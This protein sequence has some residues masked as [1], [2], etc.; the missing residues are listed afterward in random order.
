MAH[1]PRSIA[2]IFLNKAKEEGVELTALK[3]QKLV[4]YAAGYYSAATNEPLMNCSIEAWEYGPVV[5]QLYHEFK[6]F[7]GKPITRF[8]SEHD[9]TDDPA[10]LPLNDKNAMQVADFV[11][12]NYK[13]YSAL[14]LSE[15]THRPNSPWHKV[16]SSRPGVRDADI[17]EGLL[18]EHFRQFVKKSA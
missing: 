6:E 12:N 3:L 10:P 1:S 18:A 16:R 11:W 14:Q 13:K 9:F 7:G 2:N 5:P 8:A 4:Y 17:D 15:M